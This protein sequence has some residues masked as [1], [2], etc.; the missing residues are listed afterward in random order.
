MAQPQYEQWHSRKCVHQECAVYG[1]GWFWYQLTNIV[2]QNMWTQ[3]YWNTHTMNLFLSTYDYI[4][5][6]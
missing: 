4:A 6:T 1:Q 3:S 2:L 5:S